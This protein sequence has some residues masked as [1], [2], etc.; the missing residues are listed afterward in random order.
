M[1]IFSDLSEKSSGLEK[2]GLGV[3]TENTHIYHNT[4]FTTEP[5]KNPSEDFNSGFY[6]TVCGLF[7]S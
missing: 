4:F 5:Q 7:E 3:F 1:F 6:V 2:S